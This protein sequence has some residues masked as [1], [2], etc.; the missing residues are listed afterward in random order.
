MAL[1]IF[2]GFSVL[3][4]LPYA[5]YCAV[6]TFYLGEV[7]GVVGSNPTGVTEI[8][9]MYGGLQ[10]GIGVFCALALLKPAFVR[11]ALLMLC[12]LTGGLA[13]VRTLGLLLDASA[14]GYT[15]GALGFE[16]VNTAVAI[17]R[18]LDS[19]AADHVPG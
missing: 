13:V 4:W 19:G 2:L 16:V 14:S 10:A 15:L 7:A 3:I 18:G 12:F 6:V 1:Q 17:V 9:S 11:P 8:R 5:L